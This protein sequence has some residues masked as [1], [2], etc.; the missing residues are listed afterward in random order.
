MIFTI[1]IYT[2]QDSLLFSDAFII[3]DEAEF[4]KKL[5]LKKDIQN[6]KLNYDEFTLIVSNS[7]K[8]ILK[9]GADK[10]PEIQKIKDSI[11]NLLIQ[12]QEEIMP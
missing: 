6:N 8:T 9:L 12:K 3:E 2:P 7:K 4:I 5:P 1:K 11:Y 10:V